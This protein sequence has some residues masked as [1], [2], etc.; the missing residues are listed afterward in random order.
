MAHHIPSEGDVQTVRYLFRAFLPL[1]LVDAIIESAEYWPCIH[2]DQSRPVLV[3]ARKAVGQG[4]KLAWCYLVSPP[5][6]EPLSKE[7]GSG[8]SRVR[9]VEVKVQGHD[10]GWGEPNFLT[11]THPGPWSWFEAII[12]KAFRQ[13]SLIWLPAALN[14]PVD[15]ASL[16]ARP[17]FADIFADFTRWHI[18][19]NV[20]ATQRKQEHSVVWTEEEIQGPR[21][22]GGARGREGLG[23][24]LVRELQPG[25]R[26]AILALAQQWGWEN[27]VNK[28]SIDIFYSV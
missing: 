15:P 22:A 5:V 17:A 12:I 13:S 16:M 8:H 4:L 3:D 25:D 20:I 1:E 11:A 26:I 18:A 2:T 21:D 7:Q 27:H 10:Q 28:A 24:E 9:R 23:H 14:G 19:S 6:P